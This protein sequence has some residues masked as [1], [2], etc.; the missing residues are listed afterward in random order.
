MPSLPCG[1]TP[2][3]IEHAELVIAPGR[4]AEFEEAF[5]PGHPAVAQA[6]GY[7][8]A[9]LIRQIENPRNYL[10][11]VGWETVEA[12]TVDFRQSELFQLW[13]EAVGDFFA[14]PIV[15]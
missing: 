9:R 10:L 8:W 2:G 6:A 4:E 11:L 1:A 7:R 14:T 13:R 12:H 5:A 3:V 15:I